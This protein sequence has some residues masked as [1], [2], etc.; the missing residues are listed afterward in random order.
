MHKVTD[1]QAMPV[2]ND[3][4][5]VQDLVIADLRAA[6]GQ[7]DD[8]GQ[9]LV[10]TR[11]IDD[12]EARKAI[13]LAKYGTLLQPFNGRNAYVDAYQEALDLAQY[14]KQIELEGDPSLLFT[15]RLVLR[16]LTQLRA[17]V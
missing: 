15:Y 10:D 1:A 5:C 12:I 13:G 4:P 6:I 17:R 16:I 3:H 7:A 14:F 9:L 11:V 8:F 2:K